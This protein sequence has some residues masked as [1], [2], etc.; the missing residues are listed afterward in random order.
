LQNAQLLI[1]NK[2]D[3][4][5]LRYNCVGNVFFKYCCY[6]LVNNITVGYTVQCSFI[7]NL[8]ARELDREFRA[9]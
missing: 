2:F 4:F 9:K 5:I 7:N 6:N 8:A 3:K 1:K